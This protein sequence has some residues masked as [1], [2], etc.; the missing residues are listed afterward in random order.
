VSYLSKS[1][2]AFV[3]FLLYRVFRYRK[4][5]IESN[6][7]TSYGITQQPDLE[8]AVKENYHFLAKM[9][10]QIVVPPSTR[11]LKKQMKLLPCPEFDQWLGENKSV[12]ITFGHIGNWEWAGSF[13]G[14]NYP[15]QVCALYKKIK[16]GQINKLMLNRRLTHVN[17]L[18]EIGQIG[19]L[20]RLMKK[21][22]LLVLMI[23][24]Q[25][26]GSDQ[27]IIWARFM[28]RDTAFVNGPETLALRYQLPVVYM[29]I[30][31]QPGGQ[32]ALNCI[33]IYDGEEKVEAGIITQRFADQLEKNIRSNGMEWLWSHRRWKRNKVLN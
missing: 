5:V 31:S 1:T 23:A 7:A 6:L 8:E 32:Y 28:N 16:S 18:V 25:N 14:L 10:R 26:P 12:L 17:Y 11:L 9:L 15:D 30:Q 27:G 20:L 33:P 4:A 13:I 2:D 19:E 24:D 29:N 22:P 3:A 21:K